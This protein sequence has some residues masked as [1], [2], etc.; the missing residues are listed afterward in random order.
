V[1]VYVQFGLAMC[2]I[3]LL[4]LIGT[5]YLAASMNRR[6]KADLRAALTPLAELIGGEV[7]VE[8]AEVKGRY[9]GHLA[10]GRMANAGEGPGRVFQAELV[11]PAGGAAWRLTSDPARRGGDPP[12][13]RLETRDAGVSSRLR[14]EWPTLV[15]GVLNPTTDRYRLEYDPDAGVLRFVRPMR[16]RRDIPGRDE[17]RTQLDALVALGPINRQAQGAPNADWAGGRRLD[18]EA[19]VGQEAEEL[20]RLGADGPS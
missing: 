16:T 12:R 18:E 19:V 20:R 14:P 5:A 15:Q 8:E 3:V 6:A 10:F 1:N 7:S 17:F 11:D 13:E 9:A 2:G 4:S